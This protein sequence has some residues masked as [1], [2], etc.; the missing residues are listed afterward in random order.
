MSV[1]A[2]APIH[3]TQVQLSPLPDQDSA[4]NVS[5]PASQY[6]AKVILKLILKKVS[7]KNDLARRLSTL[8]PLNDLIGDLFH[9]RT[10]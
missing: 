5:I 4:D 1:I 9:S 3:D 2:P 6:V 7:N 10:V 8:H